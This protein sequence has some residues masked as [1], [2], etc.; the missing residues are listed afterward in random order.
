M[1]MS[2][3]AVYWI[4]VETSSSDNATFAKMH[5]PEQ[6]VENAENHTCDDFHGDSDVFM[7]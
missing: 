5:S 4:V 3:A 1:I 7:F 6:Q 2:L